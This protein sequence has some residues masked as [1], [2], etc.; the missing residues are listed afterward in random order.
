MNQKS[1][2][3]WF[4]L[5]FLGL[6]TI[7]LVFATFTAKAI[8]D[9][10]R[11]AT[12]TAIAQTTATAEFQMTATAEVV[13]QTATAEAACKEQF[14]EKMPEI[15]S[16]F[17]RQAEIADATYRMALAS[18][19]SKLEDIR[20]EAFTMPE[21]WCEPSIHQA[22]IDYMDAAIKAYLEFLYENDNMTYFY[23]IKARQRLSAL[24]ELVP[25]GLVNLME[26][27][28]YFYPDFMKERN[29]EDL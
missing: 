7:G 27:K 28:G 4:V 19:V 23:I 24:N 1:N 12:A 18:Q 22:L 26:R 2:V 3:I 20:N 21:K 8:I 15:L 14:M 9:G 6:M 29:W 11:S 13:A 25:G 16:R 5:I 17:F 10:N